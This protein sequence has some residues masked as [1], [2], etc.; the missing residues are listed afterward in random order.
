MLAAKPMLC[1]ILLGVKTIGSDTIRC[2]ISLI[3]MLMS[4]VIGGKT[5]AALQ[6]NS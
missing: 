4:R 2:M 3:F 5:D 6:K 1:P